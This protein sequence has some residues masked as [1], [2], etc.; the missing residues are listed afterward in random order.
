MLKITQ[1]NRLGKLEGLEC[2]VQLEELY[3]SFNGI[4]TI[5]G[6]ET[7]VSSFPNSTFPFLHSVPH[8]SL[9]ILHSL[10]PHTPFSHSSYSIPQFL[11]PHSP[12]IYILQCP[13]LHALFFHSPSVHTPFPYTS[14]PHNPVSHHS[15]PLFRMCSSVLKALFSHS[16]NLHTPIL[17]SQ[18]QPDNT[19][20]GQQQ[21][22]KTTECLSYPQT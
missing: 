3:V 8:S 14:I 9:F 20:P 5:E 4:K 12:I 21:D 7:L 16:P 19:G 6:L 10:I 22:Q 1:N 13:I 11:I 18:G 15:I 17:P 2:L